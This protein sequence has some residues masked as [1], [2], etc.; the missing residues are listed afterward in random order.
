MI[1]PE[2]LLGGLVR[3]SLRRRGRSSFGGLNSVLGMGALGV[4]IAAFEHFSEAQKATPQTPPVP[5][6]KPTASPPPP[7]IPSV[8]QPSRSATPPPL[9]PPPEPGTAHS[10]P[11]TSAS[12]P[13]SRRALLLVRAM[14]AAAN[15]DGRIDEQER[16]LILRRLEEDKITPEERQ[17]LS[18]ELEHPPSLENLLS[19]VDSAACARQV[20]AASLLAIKVDTEAERQY[21]AE[22]AGRLKLEE[23]VISEL[24][25]QF[26]VEPG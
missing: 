20:Y 16:R 10:R 18:D 19:E 8:G 2:R 22:L 6:P 11:P 3:H 14:I 15:A 26:G 23:A 1:D 12:T 9:P 5:A 24:H 25:R 7:P 4:A 17:F 21:L 13:E